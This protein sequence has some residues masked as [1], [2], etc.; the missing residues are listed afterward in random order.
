MAKTNELVLLSD[1]HV[2]NEVLFNGGNIR[3]NFLTMD[4]GSTGLFINENEYS[5]AYCDCLSAKIVRVV[6]IEAGETINAGNLGLSITPSVDMGTIRLERRHRRIVE[7]FNGMTESIARYYSVKDINGGSVQNNGELNATLV[8][9]YLNAESNLTNAQLSLYH[10]A[11]NETNWNGMGGFHDPAGKTVTYDNFQSFSFVTLGPSYSALPVTLTSFSAN[12]NQDGIEI[13]WTTA[14]EYNSAYFS[15][16]KSKDGLSWSEV[17]QLHAAGTTNQSTNY[18]YQDNKFDGV[19]YYRLVQTDFDGSFEVFTPIS[20]NCEAEKS[21]LSVS[22]NP[23]AGDFLVTI[24]TTESIESLQIEM[25]DLSGRIIQIKELSI[26]SGSN[27]VQFETEGLQPGTYIIH[28]K[29]KNQKFAPIRI[30]VI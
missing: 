26:V 4:L 21:S 2:S 23:T 14:S 19:S 6:N 17:V 5:H 30:V 16:Q 8:F 22:P 11:N 28:I 29:G 24:Q 10:R 20:V 12:C 7:P 27:F 1:I 18:Y 25:M 9:N 15:V 13:R 3:L